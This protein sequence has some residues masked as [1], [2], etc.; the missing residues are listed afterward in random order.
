M[1]GWHHGLNGHESEQ[2]LGDGE[3]QGSVACCN[4]WG[5]KES[6]TT[7]RLNNRSLGEGLAG[8]TGTQNTNP[9]ESIS[10]KVVARPT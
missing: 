7:E 10:L 5:R 3:G 4:P 8:V 6:D 9:E 2:T 1:I